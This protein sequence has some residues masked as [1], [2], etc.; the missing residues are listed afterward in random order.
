MPYSH[1]RNS[2]YLCRIDGCVQHFDTRA[3][4]ER[5]RKDKHGP[6]ET[7]PHRRYVVPQSR[8]YMMRNHLERVHQN[9]YYVQPDIIRKPPTVPSPAVTTYVSASVSPTVPNIFTCSSL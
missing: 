9:Y 3:K 4:L 2:L 1:L 8:P 6:T 7:F 5:H